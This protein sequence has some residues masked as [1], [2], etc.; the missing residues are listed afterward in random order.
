[1][2]FTYLELI[3]WLHKHI[4]LNPNSSFSL[5]VAGSTL[6]AHAI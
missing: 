1:M 3:P 4:Q 2:S 6:F 5:G